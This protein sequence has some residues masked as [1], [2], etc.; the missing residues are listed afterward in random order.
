VTEETIERQPEVEAAAGDRERQR[1]KLIGLIGASLTLV[2]LVG[3]VW[4]F[5]PGD[6]SG[7]GGVD[8][9]GLEQVDGTLVVVENTRLVLRAFEP[10]DGQSEI[11]FTIREDDLQNFDIAHLQSHSAVALPT[12]IYYEKDGGTY[13][14][15]YKEDAPANSAQQ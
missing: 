13:Y 15:V 10:L 9:S 5:G 4:L 2:A 6:D 8:T 11:E 7:T 1:A 3:L 14:A 12:R